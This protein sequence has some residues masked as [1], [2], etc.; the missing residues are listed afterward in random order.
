MQKVISKAVTWSDRKFLVKD[1]LLKMSGDIDRLEFPQDIADTIGV[2]KE[3]I[4]FWKRRGCRFI[5]RKTT[6]RWVRQFMATISGGAD[7]GI[8]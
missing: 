1:P 4:N 3:T 2:R 5:G 6:V 7:H 8:A